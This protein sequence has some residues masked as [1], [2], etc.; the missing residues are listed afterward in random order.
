MMYRESPCAGEYERMTEERQSYLDR[1]RD[2]AGVTIPRVFPKEGHNYSES[3]ITPFNSVGAKGVNN[4]ASAM[5]LS[6]LPP[7]GNP[8]FRLVPSPAFMQGIPEEI[9]DTVKQELEQKFMD[10]ERIVMREIELSNYRPAA[11]EAIKHLL[12]GGNVMVHVQEDNTLRHISLENYV[13]KRDA[14]GHLLKAIIKERV[15]LSALPQDLVEAIEDLDEQVDQDG[16]VDLYTKIEVA[17]EGEY[18]VVQSALNHELSQTESF[19]ERDYCPFIPLRLYH[20]AAESYG[21]GLVEEYY[22]D[23]VSLEGLT[24]ALVEFSAAASR[25]L[26]LVSP[27]GTTDQRDL[28][29]APNGSIITGNASDVSV[30][31]MQK[32]ADFR[33][34][35]ETSERIQQRM[36]HVFLLTTDM[37]RQAERVTAEEVRLTQQ[38]IEKQHGA[39]YSMLAVTFQLPLV[40]ILLK[41]MASQDKLPDL[42]DE[43]IDPMIIT[44][45]DAMG[46]NAD[47]MRLDS[48]VSGIGQLL[49][50]QVIAER[51]NTG[52]YLRRRANSLGIDHINLIATDE[53]IRAQQ[54]QM[55]QQQQAAAA[56]QVGQPFI[57]ESAKYAF[58]QE[59]QQ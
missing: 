1:A 36:N 2:C 56:A 26:F 25:V 8:F 15:H 4:L 45:V 54:Q 24:K 35:A 53:E 32:F 41:Q 12:I 16:E 39:A 52:E 58:N 13:V 59:P 3:F 31:Q 11:F 37:I 44:G 28:A 38:Q 40:R 22:G 55:A 14:S 7:Q 50:P 30:L 29:Q 46:R 49:G 17:E 27:N 34:T 19:Y 10:F 23:M 48:F 57:E 42:P 43:S 51:V 47:L 6:L 33:I 9:R 5:L 21:R 18:R 20:V